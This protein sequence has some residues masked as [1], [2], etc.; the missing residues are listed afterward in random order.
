M[1]TEL[2]KELAAFMF[3]FE[4]VFDEQWDRVQLA[5]GIHPHDQKADFLVHDNYS[6]LGCHDALVT[7]YQDLKKAMAARNVSIDELL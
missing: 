1:D 2:K 6:D 5:M 7:H 4:Q 3:A